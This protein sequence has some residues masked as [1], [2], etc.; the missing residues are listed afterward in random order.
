MV[1]LVAG[2]GSV[3]P[4]GHLRGPGTFGSL[5]GAAFFSHVCTP[6]ICEATVLDLLAASDSEQQQLDVLDQAVGEPGDSQACGPPSAR[7][8]RAHEICLIALPPG[9][10]ATQGLLG[11]LRE[12]F[13][14]AGQLHV[15]RD[16][17][18]RR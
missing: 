4:L 5:C 2:Q 8:V 6:G 16:A 17:L 15:L 3:G 14:L 9:A 12:Q 11:Q 13:S 10:L 1:L 18:V 7:F